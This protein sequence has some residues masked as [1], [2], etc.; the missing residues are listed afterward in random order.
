MKVDIRSKAARYYDLNPDFPDDIPFYRERIPSPDVKVL[1]LGCGTGRVLVPLVQSCAY[2]EGI[3]LSEA[4]VSTCREKL[5]RASIPTSQARVVVGDISDF[6]LGTKF[7]LIIA[8]FRVF[9]NLETDVE[10]QG[11]SNCVRRHL[12]PG[13]SCIL[14][15]FN[16]KTDKD[17]MRREWC[18]DK[19]IFCWDVPVEGGRVTCH[20][21]RKRIDRDRLILY[22]QLI[23][24]H[25]E[26]QSL[27]HTAVLKIVMRCYYPDEF[28]KIIV[29]HRF[30]VVN[31]WGGYHEE[32]Y[33]EGSELVLQF[34]A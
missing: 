22:P 31:R 28:E 25:Y 4:M 11:F 14:N 16:P 2:I 7:D 8:P 10:V 33:S 26:A 19:E 21:M 17:T 9:Q 30:R 12:A 18:T 3:D 23:Y 15:A 1:E 13:G 29:D 34:A 24:R 20:D 32:R 5:R 6:D 27:R